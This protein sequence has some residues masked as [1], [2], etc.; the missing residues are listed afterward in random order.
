[1]VG[2]LTQLRLK[3]ERRPED[4]DERIEQLTLELLRE[5]NELSVDKVDL[6]KNHPLILGEKV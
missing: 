6:I 3:I 5:L 2:K 4:D 1:M